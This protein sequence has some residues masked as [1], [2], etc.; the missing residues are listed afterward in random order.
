M[1]KRSILI[2]AVLTLSAAGALAVEPSEV[3][4][5]GGKTLTG[6]L[7]PVLD[8]IYLLQTEETLY[9]LSGS[10]IVR[11]DGG[12]DL[13]RIDTRRKFAATSS[14][15]RLLPSGD[16]EIS[17]TMTIRNRG[18]HIQTTVQWGAAP[19]EV[20]MYE[21]MRTLDIYGHELDYRLEP[22]GGTNVM[23]VIVDLEVPVMPGEDMDLSIRLLHRGSATEQDGVW[24]YTHWGDYAEDRLQHLKVE[25]PAGAEILSV[26]PPVRVVEYDGRQFVFW[27]RYYPKGEQYPL[28]VSYR[29]D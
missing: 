11:V 20:R 10:E 25:L 22:R 2:I 13:P 14:Y 7:R 28:T 6:V 4:L 26:N 24:T 19:H 15:N 8:S 29:L 3:E 21:T 1:S 12:T 17:S 23:N 18:K 9:E 16:L 27:R 5:K